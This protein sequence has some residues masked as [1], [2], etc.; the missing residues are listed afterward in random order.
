MLLKEGHEKFC[1]FY[2]SI[3]RHS[4]S[5]DTT[6]KICGICSGRFVLQLNNVRVDLTQSR[7][8]KFA[9][10]VKMHYASERKAGKKHGEVMKILSR[11]FKEVFFA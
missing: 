3:V 11:C 8:N 9:N 1:K 7:N 6:R 10:F 4:K 5:L 2:Y